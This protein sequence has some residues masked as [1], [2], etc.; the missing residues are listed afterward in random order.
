MDLVSGTYVPV[1]VLVR[2]YLLTIEN[3]DNICFVVVQ[4]NQISSAKVDRIWEHGTS[5]H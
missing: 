3:S 1:R 4:I 2:K 5:G